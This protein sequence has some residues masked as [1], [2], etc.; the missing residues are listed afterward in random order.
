VVELTC[1]E[2]TELITDYLEERLPDTDRVRFEE[3]LALCEACVNYVAQ[4]RETT[5]A[6][7]ASRRVEIPERMETE[8]LRVFRGWKSEGEDSAIR[9]VR[10]KKF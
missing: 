4:M 10:P 9:P 7:G 6:L 5:W 8:L 2:L 3:H 1:K